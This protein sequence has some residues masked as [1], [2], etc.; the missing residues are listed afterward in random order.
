MRAW[1]PLYQV[2]STTYIA[3]GV[4][5][6]VGRPEAHGSVNV[7]RVDVASILN[8]FDEVLERRLGLTAGN[9]I[10]RAEAAVLGNV[11]PHLVGHHPVVPQ[12]L[13]RALVV[14]VFIKQRVANLKPPLIG[15]AKQI[16]FMILLIQ[17]DLY[18]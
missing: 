17:W 1:I 4:G 10:G 14:L 16:I 18:C 11:V 2:C 9:A 15:G 8:E 12:E 6:P 13:Q 5:R 3:T 7:V